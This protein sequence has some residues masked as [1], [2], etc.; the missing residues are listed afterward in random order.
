MTDIIPPHVILINKP[1]HWTSFDVVNK[2]RY[3]LL[4]KIRTILEKNGAEVK[5]VKYKVGHAGTLDPLATGLLIICTGR[6]TKN[7]DTYMAQEKEYTGIIFLGAT[8]PS[9]DN[10]TEIEATFDVSTITKENIFETAK[11]FTGEIEQQPPIFSA[12]KKDGK[13][14]YKSARAGEEIKLDSRKI[15]INEF[16]ITK[17][18]MPLV[19]FRIMCSKGTYIRSIANDF[20][21]ALNSGGYLHSLCRTRIGKYKLEDAVSVEE[22]VNLNNTD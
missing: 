8:R 17:I 18:E 13:A 16:E 3:V 6:E 22:F 9:F 15:F 5:K 1:L 12:I 20:G 21:K 4:K 2:I 19:H 7:I 11:K 10:E 14:A